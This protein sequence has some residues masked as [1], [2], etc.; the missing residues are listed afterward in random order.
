MAKENWAMRTQGEVRKRRRKRNRI[1]ISF[2]GWDFGCF[3]PGFGLDRLGRRFL[4]MELGNS[5]WMIIKLLGGSIVLDRKGKQHY[6]SLYS[7]SLILMQSQALIIIAL[8]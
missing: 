4:L 6:P 3:G 2:W 8:S 5:G 1:G 7:S